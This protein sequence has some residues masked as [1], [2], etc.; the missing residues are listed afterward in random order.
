MKIQNGFIC[1]SSTQTFVA[2]MGIV[3]DEEKFNKFEEE[4]GCKYQRL[5]YKEICDN[6]EWY[7]RLY[8]PDEKYKDQTFIL[9][10]ESIDCDYDENSEAI[11]VEFDEFSKRTK[12]LA[13]SKDDIKKY[14]FK[15][16][17]SVED[18]FYNG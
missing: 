14:G 16:I 4:N 3:I 17:Q 9:E 8:K 18:T 5:T 11:E 2:F 10:T 15:I 13:I 7:D 12:I 6:I 1:N